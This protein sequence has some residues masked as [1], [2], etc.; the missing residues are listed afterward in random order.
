M[1]FAIAEWDRDADG[2]MEAPQFNT[3]D[4]VIFGK[5]TFVSSLYLAAL[6]AA[7]E[8]A[9]L[10]RDEN[11]AARYRGLFEK[12]A[13]SRPSS[14]FNGEDYIQIADNLTSYGKVCLADKWSARGGPAC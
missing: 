3:Y 14:S 2:I 5:N 4:R 9:R 6:R 12:G 8:M 10:S 11:A 1:D 13:A 7:E